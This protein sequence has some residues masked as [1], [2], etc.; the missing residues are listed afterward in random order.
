MSGDPVA[1]TPASGATTRVG[2]GRRLAAITLDWIVALLLARL[3]LP[4]VTYGSGDFALATMLIFAFEIIALTWLTGS[5]FGQRILGI[6]VVAQ[7]GQR[8]SLW[9]TIVR[10]LLI[11]VVIPALVYDSQGRGLQDLAVGS[12]VVY[13]KAR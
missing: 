13:R 6:A 11:C 2:L 4:G 9:R 1:R 12:R 7:S 5:S 8:L 10:T 3:F